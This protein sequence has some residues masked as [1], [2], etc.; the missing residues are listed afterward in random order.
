M[1]AGRLGSRLVTH[2]QAI[3]Y[4]HPHRIASTAV[5]TAGTGLVCPVCGDPFEPTKA[6]KAHCSDKCKGIAWDRENPRLKKASAQQ[7]ELALKV[8][9]KQEQPHFDG[10]TFDQ[11]KDGQR[12]TTQ[13]ERVL[14][15]MQDGEWHTLQEIVIKISYPP[16]D[17][18][19]EAGVSARLR[20]MRKPRFGGHV[21]H[22]RRKADGGLFEYRMLRNAALSGWPRKDETETEK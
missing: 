13:Y 5:A 15:V 7:L 18:A 11:A 1:G 10:A 4:D 3:R 21:I 2:F 17:Q 9:N 22:R 16:Y 14:S 20:D 12:L 19:S 8:R 6:N